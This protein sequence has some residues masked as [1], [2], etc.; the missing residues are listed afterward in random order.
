MKQHHPIRRQLDAILGSRAK[1]CVLRSLS[2]ADSGLNGR[3][4][5]RRAGLAP[6]SAQLALADLVRIGIIDMKE[7]G[8]NHIF[9]INR[10]FHL[11]SSGLGIALDEEKSTPESIALSISRT[12]RGDHVVT[13][14][15]FGSMARGQRSLDSDM[16]LLVVVKDSRSACRVREKI[17]KEAPALRRKFGIRLEPYVLG[18][19]ELAARFDEKD[20]LVRNMVKDAVL[21]HG[22]PLAEVLRDVP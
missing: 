19:G 6:R 16:D 11:Y 7:V 15:W 1:V 5:A 17:I 13:I 12:I 2:G 4:V 18:S 10:G 14:A 8:N 21:L 3:E 22:K 9:S 20:P